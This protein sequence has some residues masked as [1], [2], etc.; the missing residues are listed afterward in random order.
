MD[1]ETTIS[2]IDEVKNTNIVDISKWKTFS[3]ADYFDITG[4]KTTAKYEIDSNPGPYPYVTT[5]S[6]NNGIESYSS[7]KTEEGNVLVVDSAVLGFMTYQED[8]FSA[9]D[10]VEKLIP[11]FALNKYIGIF[12]CT[13]WNKAYSGVKYD[14]Q[15]KA[16]Q[17]EIRQEKIYLP[18][19]EKGELDF[20]FMETYIKESIF[21]SMLK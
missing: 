2:K 13:V 5:R 11:K 18:A 15:R 21:G 8:P 20:E 12:I 14:Y 3:I 7:I 16:S 4:T 9:S 10:H 17:T 6:T 1:I 19:N